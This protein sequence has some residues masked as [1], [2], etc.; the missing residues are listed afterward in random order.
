MQ[1]HQY[2]RTVQTLWTTR[3]GEKRKRT[4]FDHGEAFRRHS[5]ERISR[6]Y[7]Y[8]RNQRIDRQN[9]WLLSVAIVVAS[10]FLIYDQVDKASL[11]AYSHMDTL[12]ALDGTVSAVVAVPNHVPSNVGTVHAA[13]V[14][15]PTGRTR[16]NATQ[17]RHVLEQSTTTDKNTYSVKDLLELAPQPNGNDVEIYNV[18]AWHRLRRLLGLEQESK[19][20]STI[21]LCSLGGSATAGAGD[22]EAVYRWDSTFVEMLKV[23][24]PSL[25]IKVMNRG[26]GWRASIHSALLL[27]SFV[28]PET[29][30][31]LWEFAMNDVHSKGCEEIN[32]G[33]RFW[34]DQ[35]AHQFSPPPLVLLA[36]LWNVN[37]S[38]DPLSSLV[39]QCHNRIAAKYDFVV[40]SVNLHS[41]FDKDP[42][43]T[44]DTHAMQKY[45]LLDRSHPGWWGHQLLGF[46]LWDLVTNDA[47]K[48][49]ERNGSTLDQATQ[50][51]FSCPANSP[52]KKKIL[53]IL[54]TKPILASWTSELPHNENYTRGMM[55][56]QLFTKPD[57]ANMDHI[58][59]GTN[60]MT[61]VLHGKTS[62]ARQDRKLALVLPCCDSGNRIGF[63]LLQPLTNGT[64][65]RRLEERQGTISAI[66]LHAPEAVKKMN[67]K[68]AFQLDKGLVTRKIQVEVWEEEG[69]N[70]TPI[71]LHSRKGKGNTNTT[72][73]MDA[74]W[75]TFET[76]DC[77]LGDVSI[78]PWL[79][80]PDDMRLSRIAMC[81]MDPKCGQADK[82]KNDNPI[83]L[84]HVVLI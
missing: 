84:M 66:L 83:S 37:D 18:E 40:G 23:T 73:M 61:Y 69:A 15:V 41:Y 78:N 77:L 7:T 60:N 19:A 53:D 35:V 6:E 1:N 39:Y 26:H 50:A 38:N 13:P 72:S 65:H 58:K 29:D 79:V 64:T 22:I 49:V 43:V 71:V 75:V 52:A 32:S 56:P 9:R 62:D 81:N 42:T 54:Q 59:Q 11:M 27:Q 34:L 33:I 47:R 45:V 30:I 4:R 5:F 14:P 12:H 3:F 67:G 48:T 8:K 55:E 31:L 10:S 24:Q 46:L 21:T 2:S 63:D 36:Y 28:P 76:E 20:T 44:W 25:D 70:G 74:E 17:L 57:D 82:K 51:T 68:G 80:L 16:W